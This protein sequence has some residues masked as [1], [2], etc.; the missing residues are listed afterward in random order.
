MYF[1]T[2]VYYCQVAMVARTSCEH[3]TY[4]T[5]ANNSWSLLGAGVTKQPHPSTGGTKEG[6]LG[7][8]VVRARGLQLGKETKK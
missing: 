2:N 3:Q 7:R 5:Q 4:L 6:E 1:K 8:G